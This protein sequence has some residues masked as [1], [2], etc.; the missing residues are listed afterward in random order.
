[1]YS[2]GVEKIKKK[3]ETGIFYL[4][5]YID[6]I[7]LCFLIFRFFYLYTRSRLQNINN[8]LL[9][10]ETFRLNRS[11]QLHEKFVVVI[12]RFYCS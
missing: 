8:V 10:A 12:I 11:L 7:S 5:Q 4:S 3:R 1:M 2:I 9:K 6:L